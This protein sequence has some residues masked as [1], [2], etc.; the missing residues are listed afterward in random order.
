MVAAKMADLKQG[1]RGQAK[2]TPK[3]GT[4]EDKVTIDKAAEQLNVSPRSVSRAKA[5]QD[6][7]DDELIKSVEQGG[8]DN[9]QE[10][11]GGSKARSG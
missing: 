3:G 7:G 5:V 9:Y 8:R 6:S 11:C 2:E 4:H 1:Q 10:P